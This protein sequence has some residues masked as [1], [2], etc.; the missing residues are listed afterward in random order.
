M[1]SPQPGWAGLCVFASRQLPTES[2]YSRHLDWHF[3]RRAKLD[4]NS[5]E[6][7]SRGWCVSAEQWLA[8][9]VE[10][11]NAE[12]GGGL[13][14]A[15]GEHPLDEPA[16]EEGVSIPVDEAQEA[17]TLCGESFEVFWH[18]DEEVRPPPVGFR[19]NPFE[20]PLLNFKD[21]FKSLLNCKERIET[22]VGL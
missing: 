3:V 7:Q 11:H 20:N 18:A 5:T 15:P 12:G 1:N 6:I 19:G 17:C 21:L 13:G 16:A 4:P 22:P 2:E 14:F 9:V 10:T 8:G